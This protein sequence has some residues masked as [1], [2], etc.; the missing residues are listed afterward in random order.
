MTSRITETLLQSLEARTEEVIEKSEALRN[1]IIGETMVEVD[2]ELQ[3]SQVLINHCIPK[4]QMSELCGW[5]SVNTF[6]KNEEKWIADGLVKETIKIKGKWAYS[7][8]H[9]HRILDLLG[10]PKWADKKRGTHI[11][12]VQNQKGGTGKSSLLVNTAQSIALKHDQRLNILIIDL[13]PQGSLRTFTKPR[14]YEQEDLDVVTAVDVMLGDLEPDSLYQTFKSYDFSHEDIIQEAILDTELPNVKV[15]TAFPED[16]RFSSIAWASGETENMV[17][18][19]KE[20]IIDPIRDDYDLIFI[21]SGP[22]VNPLT[23]SAL[24]ASNGVLCPVTPQTLDWSSTIQFIDKIPNM[25]RQL[26]DDAEGVHWFK[27]CVT[28]YDGRTQRDTEVA[29]RIKDQ[30]GSF[31]FNQYVDKYHVFE[32]AARNHRTVMDISDSE[33]LAP[34]AQ[35]EG[36]QSSVNQFSNLLLNHLKDINLK[37]V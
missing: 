36:A 15:I 9:I 6:N 34:K 18:L 3:L 8:F 19:L 21:D 22:Q 29:N 33:K 1:K 7:P 28:N 4:T 26:P 30:Y 17:K 11:I 13:D 12:N 25:I 35:V 2:E 23:W 37:E 27:I 24:Y 14:S 16:E 32:I 5:Q 31:V 20:R 10:K